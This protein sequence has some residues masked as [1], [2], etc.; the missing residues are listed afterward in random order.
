MDGVVLNLPMSDNYETRYFIQG[1]DETDDEEKDD[2]LS[3][4]ENP[5]FA[6]NESSHMWVY[7]PE[8]ELLSIITTLNMKSIKIYDVAGRTVGEQSFTVDCTQTSFRLPMGMYVLEVKL[9]NNEVRHVK[10]LVK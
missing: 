4:I 6:N 10:A 2:E 7:T 3:S 9:E 1:P 8:P 5:L